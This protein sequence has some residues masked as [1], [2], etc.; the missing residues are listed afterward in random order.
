MINRDLCIF[1]MNLILTILF[2][3]CWISCWTGCCFRWESFTRGSPSSGRDE[4]TES[5]RPAYPIYLKNSEFFTQKFQDLSSIIA[6]IWTL[7]LV[8]INT[9][10]WKRP[11]KF[12]REPVRRGRQMRVTRYHLREEEEEG[13]EALISLWWWGTMGKDIYDKSKKITVI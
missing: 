11:T 7:N 3:C 13:A 6:Q 1:P 4:P 5:L 12:R 10:L 8:K 2:T 9:I